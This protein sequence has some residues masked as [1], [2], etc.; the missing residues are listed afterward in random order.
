MLFTDIKQK[1]IDSMKLPISL[2]TVTLRTQLAIE[3]HEIAKKQL[4]FCENMVHDQHLQQQGN[5]YISSILFVIVL[6]HFRMVCCNS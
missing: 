1:L 3:Y 6:F 5:L 2:D 4:E